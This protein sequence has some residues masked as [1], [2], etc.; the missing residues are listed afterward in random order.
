MEILKSECRKAA[1]AMEKATG[2]KAYVSGGSWKDG[3]QDFVDVMLEI[4]DVETG[5]LLGHVGMVC[6]MFDRRRSWVNLVE[7]Y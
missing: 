6:V 5:R 7:E 4:C 2:R 3:D 1:R